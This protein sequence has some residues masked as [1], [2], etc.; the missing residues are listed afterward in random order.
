M[1]S[2]SLLALATLVAGAFASAAFAADVPQK[3]DWGDQGDGTYKNPI[4]KA[5]YS[6]PDVIRV[7]SDYY[8]IAS[9]FHF[10]GMQILH[11]RDLVNW[12]VLGQVFSKLTMSPIYDQMNGYAKGT[13]APSLRFHNGEFYIY[14]CTPEGLYMW[15]TKNP[16]GPWSDT[17]TVRAVANWEDPCPFWDDD[18]TGY[19]VHSRQGA[20]P[21]ILHKLSADNTQLIDEGTPIYTGPTAEGPKMFK[22]NGPGGSMYYISLPEGGVDRGSQ[23]VIRS[24][25]IKGPY[26]KKTV[27]EAGAPHQGGIVDTP[28]GKESWFIG[29]K[30]AGWQGRVAN[31][32]PVVWGE[33]GWP[34]FGDDGKHVLQHK[35]PNLHADK[36]SLPKLSDDFSGKTLDPIWQWNHN[37]VNENWSLAENALHLKALP[38]TSLTLARNTLTQK[39]WGDAG[40]VTVTLSTK[41][42]ADGQIAGLTFQ[43]GNQFAWMGVQKSGSST[44]VAANIPMGRGRVGAFG[45]GPAQPNTPT[46]TGPEVTGSIFLRASYEP[47]PSQNLASAT[48]AGSFSFSLDNKTFTQIPNPANLAFQSW[49]GARIALFSLGPNPGTADF[50]N[51]QYQVLPAP[52]P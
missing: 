35:K 39:L 21:L 46:F 47:V 33:D 10:V 4:L 29:F 40:T 15:H 36:P 20:G 38:A 16:A 30:S 7:G 3:L 1:P 31:L 6:D 2:R 51:F 34:T 42:L 8:L 14:V 37:P 44:R 19:L 9:D 11:S 23:V 52:A 27:L 26:E 5:D 12:T 50:S 22:R 28:D 32:E 13:W 41:N 43:S 49:K 24:K 17:V 45:G 25:T 18:G 48:G